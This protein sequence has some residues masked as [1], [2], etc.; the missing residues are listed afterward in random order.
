M[1]Y[2]IYYTTNPQFC[3]AFFEIPMIRIHP[4]VFITTK[5]GNLSQKQHKNSRL[6][7][8][9]NANLCR[10]PQNDPAAL[11]SKRNLKLQ[12]TMVT[13]H[14]IRMNHNIDH[15]FRNAV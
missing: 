1:K 4:A 6:H 5:Q 3:H 15:L 12:R 10:K 8:F 11:V 13:A 9:P 7:S 2:N 14:D